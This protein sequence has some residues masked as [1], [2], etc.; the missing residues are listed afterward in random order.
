VEDQSG[1]CF[2]LDG[3]ASWIQCGLGRGVWAVGPETA[4]GDVI[5]EDGGEVLLTS[6]R[7]LRI[8]EA[9]LYLL[10]GCDFVLCGC[11]VDVD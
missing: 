3:R 2:L 8:V 10:G 5:Q 4:L 11:G 1:L 9:A 7:I 6:R